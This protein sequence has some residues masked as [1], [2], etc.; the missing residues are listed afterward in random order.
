MPATPLG[1][2]GVHGIDED[3]TGMVIESI[4]DTTKKKSNFLLDKVGCRVGRADYDHSVEI[5]IKGQFTASTPWAQKVSAEI[6][7]A[8]TISA[9]HLPSGLGTGMTLIDEVQRSRGRE[10]WQGLTV[11]AEM[12][13]AF[14]SS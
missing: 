11:A 8:N 4:E 13:P 3:E 2:V 5:T 1:T 6:T 9:A 10:D 12:L 14:P 7:L